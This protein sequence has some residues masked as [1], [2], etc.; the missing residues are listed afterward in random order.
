ML[1]FRRKLRQVHFRSEQERIIHWRL[2]REQR[3]VT[4]RAK[5]KAR[6]DEL[7]QVSLRRS[8]A[9]TRPH[10]LRLAQAAGEQLRALEGNLVRVQCRLRQ[11]LQARR[12]VARLRHIRPVAVPPAD[13]RL[14]SRLGRVGHF[15]QRL[16]PRIVKR[17]HCLGFVFDCG[18]ASD[19]HVENCAQLVGR[20]QHRAAS[21]LGVEHIGLPGRNRVGLAVGIRLHRAGDIL[22]RH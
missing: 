11:L 17:L 20:D 16:E 6:I 2:S 22:L 19:Q 21:L 3:A 10:A 15:L 5:R 12:Q 14:L 8:L 13:Q 18:A 4:G 1:F 9:G 7:V